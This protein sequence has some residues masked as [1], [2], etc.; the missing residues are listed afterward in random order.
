[1]ARKKTEGTK[2]AE[3]ETPEGFKYIIR[4]VNTDVDGNRKMVDALTMIKGVNYRLSKAI[5]DILDLPY[6][7][8]AGELTDEEIEKLEEVLLNLPKHLPPWMLNHRKDLFSGEDIHYLSSDLDSS[9][10]DDI[11]HLKKIR[12]YRGIRHETGQKVRGQRT[13]SNGRSGATIGVVRRRR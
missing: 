11:N 12:C 10:R 5:V 7:K 6:D 9:R 3:D 2:P 1:M 8:K 4:L 13:R